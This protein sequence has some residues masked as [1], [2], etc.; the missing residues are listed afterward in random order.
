MKEYTNQLPDIPKDLFYDQILDNSGTYSDEQLTPEYIA[1]I[2]DLPRISFRIYYSKD[3]YRR[4]IFVACPSTAVEKLL[5]FGFVVATLNDL[6]HIPNREVDN[7]S[8]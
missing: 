2:L 6:Q 7:N 8:I 3:R 5:H 1:T 4:R